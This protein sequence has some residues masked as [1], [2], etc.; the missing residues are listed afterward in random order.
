MAADDQS[1]YLVGEVL[2]NALGALDKNRGRTSRL[3]DDL[4]SAEK[5]TEAARIQAAIDGG[6]YT[7]VETDPEALAL[8][9]GVVSALL[10]IL[11]NGA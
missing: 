11:I 6:D 2:R 3:W 4:S 7:T 5:A 9:T 8:E 10:T 1:K